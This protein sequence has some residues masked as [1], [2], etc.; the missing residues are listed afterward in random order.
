MNRFAS[1]FCVAA[2]LPILNAQQNVTQS[3]KYYPAH[4]VL[5]T[6]PRDKVSSSLIME[7]MPLVAPLF[8]EDG[9]MSSDLMLV[10]N[11]AIDA[12]ITITTRNLQGVEIG[13]LHTKLIPNEQRHFSAASPF[14]RMPISRVKRSRRNCL[15]R[16]IAIRHLRIWMKNWLCRI[17]KAHRCCVL[18]PM[19]CRVNRFWLLPILPLRSRRSRCS[20]LGLIGSVYLRRSR[21]NHSPHRFHRHVPGHPCRTSRPF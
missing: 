15:S 20:A 1:A 17:R 14:F 10:N 4:P 5:Q 7:E 3:S 6:P 12:G 2:F 11:S 13:H 18:L 9:A 16:T 8:I 19:S 21:F